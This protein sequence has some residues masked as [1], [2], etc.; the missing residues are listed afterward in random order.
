MMSPARKPTLRS[1]IG[2]F[3]IVLSFM[4][5]V[6]GLIIPLFNLSATATTTLVAFFM[7]G[8]PEIFLIAGGALAGKEG[9]DLVKNKIKRLF[10]LP[11]GRYSAPRSQY[12]LALAIMIL[13]FVSLFLPFYIPS[14][15]SWIHSLTVKWYYFVIGDVVF[16]LAFLFL[17][18]D[19]LITK[20]GKLMTW[21]PW[22]LP[23]PKEH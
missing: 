19:Q 5:P 18:G 6:F 21:E 20:L 9:I 3:L 12:N 13:W 15:D 17:G 7:V 14:V 11:E 2:V 8:G 16:V 4:C 10:G 23:P 1:R 22:E